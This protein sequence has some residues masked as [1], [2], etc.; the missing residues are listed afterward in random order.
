M[1]RTW[2]DMKQLRRRVDKVEDLRHEQE[3]KSFAEMAKDTYDCKHHPSEI[4]ISVA[5][6]NLCRIPV[7]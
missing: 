5:D 1:S 6:E 7:L 4:A 2:N 3:Q